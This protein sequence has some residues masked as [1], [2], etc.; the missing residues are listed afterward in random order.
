MFYFLETDIRQQK[1]MK[2]EHRTSVDNTVN[3]PRFEIKFEN[4]VKDKNNCF[5]KRDIAFLFWTKMCFILG[6]I[7]FF[8]FFWDSKNLITSPFCFVDADTKKHRIASAKVSDAALVKLTDWIIKNVH[9]VICAWFFC[10]WFEHDQTSNVVWL[11][12]I[13]FNLSAGGC[14]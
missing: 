9:V 12:N 6:D 8:F 2:W 3:D 4:C 7:F 1:S 10:K 14:K 5:I 13:A 11:R